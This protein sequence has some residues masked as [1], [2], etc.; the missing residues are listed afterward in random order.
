MS[1]GNLFRRKHPVGWITTI[2][3]FFGALWILFSDNLV[4]FWLDDPGSITQ[5]QTY[6]GWFFV[7]ASGI[8]IYSIVSPV[9]KNLEKAQTNIK[10][11]EIMQKDLLNRHYQPLWQTDELGHCIFSNEKWMDLTGIHLPSHKPFSWI[12]AAH[13]DDKTGCIQKFTTGFL[14]KEAFSFSYRVI[15]K[16]KKYRWFVNSCFP[17]HNAQNEFMGMICLLFDINDS[18]QLEIEYKQNFIWYKNLFS[19]HPSPMLIYNTHNL[20]ILD[21]NESALQKYGYTREEFLKLTFYDLLVTNSND[22]NPEN[23]LYDQTYEFEKESNKMHK[24]KFGEAF[25]AEVSGHEIP[26]IAEKNKRLILVRDI[27]NDLR[28]QQ[29]KEFQTYFLELIINNIPFPLFYKDDKG[30]YKGCNISFCNFLNKNKEE[31]I[32]CTVFDIFDHE[33]ANEFH[34]KDLELLKSRS[35]QQYETL[36]EFPDGRKMNA[37]FHKKVFMSQEKQPM[38]IIG[39]YFDITERIKAEAVI[40]R[41]MEELSKINIEL[42]RFSYTVSHDLRSPLVT[43]QGFLSLLREDIKSG[44]F[45]A[46]DE[47]IGRIEDATEKMHQLIEGLL[48]YSR[49]SNQ[50][51]YFQQMS[52][53]KIAKEA[54]NLLYGISKINKCEIDIQPDMG[55]EMADKTQIREL[56]QNLIENAIK[57]SGTKE[58]NT[59]KIFSRLENGKNTYC[60]KDQ[61]IGINPENRVKIFE[62]FSRCNSNVSGNGLGLALVKHIIDKHHGSIWVESEG[63][64]KGS[65]FCFTLHSR[66]HANPI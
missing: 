63:E 55:Y 37:V 60:V 49:L 21:V 42:E 16:D 52:M 35:S 58:E 45:N 57:F 33:M 1:K 36:I 41:Q 3:I 17:Y 28:N 65:V 51:N 20:N 34:Q 18:K 11:K 9:L 26:D 12:T 2:Y 66:D 15:T 43:I 8:L 4:A 40:K 53:S 27:T 47:N 19:I 30:V 32:G 56:F 23:H 7:L 64:N 61:G 10:E 5:I 31:I 50:D 54:A 29:E 46:I 13:P 25:H 59:I 24:N 44:Q 6:K 39:V 62:L 22:Q 14:N 38:G 48:S